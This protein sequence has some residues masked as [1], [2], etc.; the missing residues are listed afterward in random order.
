MSRK[1]AVTRWSWAVDAVI[2]LA[3]TAGVVV[4]DLNRSYM[5]VQRE[6]AGSATP[7]PVGIPGPPLPPP[8]P[9]SLPPS[10]APHGVPHG[11]PAVEHTLP[12]VEPWELAAAVLTAMPLLLRR[13]HPL[14]TYWTVMG[15]TLLLHQG[16]VAADATTV[17]FASGLIAAYSA[18]V[19]SPRR[20]TVAAS[21]LAGVVL[22]AAFPL[23]PEVDRGLVPLL[24]LL[25]IGLATHGIHTWRQRAQALQ[26]E[27]QAA[28]RLAVD[29]ERSRIARELHDVV[30]HNV[31]MMTIQAGAARKVLDAA[32]DQAREAMLAVEAAGRSAMSEL[33][34]VMGLL[35][36]A[37]DGPDPATDVGL[38]PQPGLDQ[39]AELVDR[40]RATGVPVHLTVRGTRAELPAGVDL[41][42]YRVAQEALTNTGKHAAG[43]SVSITVEYAPGELRM[44]VA[45]TGGVPQ[46]SAGSGSG[47]G[48]VGL[49][50]R[51]AVYGGTLHA[52]RR[53]AGGYRVRAVIPVEEP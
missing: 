9:P 41:A 28:L 33:R 8:V 36:M 39:L 53:P 44:E 37:A 13:R 42:A 30:T 38:A 4:G 7:A 45:D 3:L 52:G 46:P 18:A 10:D 29:Q 23:A 31:S 17:T 12:P 50:E 27:Q 2:A 34:H 5:E 22:Y 43:A 6:P 16:D 32:P 14:A 26:E 51:L 24:V 1:E 25:P 21:L 19:H 11:V 48:L 20:K 40:V 49:R 15:A 47:S 35:T